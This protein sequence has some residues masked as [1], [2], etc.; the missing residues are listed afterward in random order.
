MCVRNLTLVAVDWFLQ[1]LA[2]QV[3]WEGHPY[4]ESSPEVRAVS[5]LAF[6]HK[7][8]TSLQLF[9]HLK[10]TL[11]PHLVP[12]TKLTSWWLSLIQRALQILAIF[13]DFSL[14]SKCRI[15]CCLFC[16]CLLYLVPRQP[17]SACVE[18][19]AP[20]HDTQERQNHK[21]MHSTQKTQSTHKKNA[22]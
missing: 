21:V 7:A 5:R 14:F 9:W 8:L 11:R 2:V 17:K 22:L 1:R 10:A 20:L 3:V 6:L 12:V 4:Q 18:G 19:R 15:E 16:L 13:H